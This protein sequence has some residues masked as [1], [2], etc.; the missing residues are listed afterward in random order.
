M[1]FDLEK[2]VRKCATILNDNSL[3][4]KLSSGDL[5]AQEA[6]YHPTCLLSLYRISR[7]REEDEGTPENDSTKQIHGQVLAELAQYMEQEKNESSHVFKLVDLA[8]LYK[9]RV[10]ELGGHISGRVHTTKLKRD[11]WH[12]SKI[13]EI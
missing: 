1:T 13:V 6:V 12:M 8:D 2:R 9:E 3:L 11:C 10:L 5:V 4:G 7:K